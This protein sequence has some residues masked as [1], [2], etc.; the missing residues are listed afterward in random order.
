MALI[1]PLV[2]SA[3]SCAGRRPGTLVLIA[4]GDCLL[5]RYDGRLVA[6]GR[7]DR[8][9]DALIEAARGSDAFLFNL[10][11]TVGEGG[12]PKD[13]RFVFR[14]PARALA[15]LSRFPHP[16]AALANN[17][18]MDYGPEGLLATL[19][20][21]D[22]AGIAYAGAGATSGQAWAE[23]RIACQGGALSVLS[24]GFDNDA[25]SFSD[26][27][28]A[29]I[30]PLDIGMLAERIRA[31]RKK[32]L[33]VVVMLHW[34]IEYD[35]RYRRSER[36]AAR[37]LVDAGADLIVGTGPHVLQGQE[38]Y[39]GAL[40]CYSLGNLVFD[41]LGSDETSSSA[42]VRMTVSPVPGGY[43]KRFEVAPLR[44]RNIARGPAC[45]TPED[46]RRIVQSIAFRSPDQ[47]LIKARPH[48]KGRGLYWFPAG[49]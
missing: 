16:V 45:P 13:K 30:A 6:K 31:C 3:L 14:A 26:S 10:E 22:K 36:L 40:I 44:T 19:S 46:A 11:T 33:A 49:E 12:R 24:A 23:A 48:P 17:H 21:L 28:G 18:S 29:A 41:D 7:D 9:W 1:L 32:S 15:P 25:S 42:V 37:A 47:G 43:K 38:S 5:D 27:F 4:G 2:L 35:T 39:H 8:R 20:A 34:G